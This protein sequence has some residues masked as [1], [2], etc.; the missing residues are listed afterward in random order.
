MAADMRTALTG[1]RVA[2]GDLLA[3]EYLSTDTSRCDV[4]NRLFTNPGA[5]CFPKGVTTIRFE[6]GVGPP[7]DPPT[8]VAHVGGHLYYY[9]YHVGGTWHWWE[10][11][12]PLACWR[13]VTRHLADDGSCRPVWLA[14]KQAAGQ[15]EMSG[16]ALD[17]GAPF[18][19]RITVH[20]TSRG[21]RSATAISEPLIDGTIAA[22]RTGASAAAAARVAAALAPHMP[23]VEAAALQALAAMSSP[24]PLF[25]TPPFVIKNS[26]V[27]ISPCD[28]RCHATDAS[29]P[30]T[31]NLW[32]RRRS[33]LEMVRLASYSKNWG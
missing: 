27:Q 30:S 7:P 10:P 9:R 19:V 17:D 8:P 31:M 29:F 6:R 20:A 16:S 22:F 2:A 25:T 13:R 24:G 21:P 3:G 32:M 1:L 11:A 26:Y 5:S 14:M 15:I 12:T 33:Q 4:E 28:E 23:S 18:G